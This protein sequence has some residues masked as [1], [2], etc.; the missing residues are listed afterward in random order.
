MSNEEQLQAIAI[1]R[2]LQLELN[3]LATSWDEAILEAAPTLR[4]LNTSRYAA[5]GFL[6]RYDGE[7]ASEVQL[8]EIFD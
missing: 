1:I 8:E 5:S 4:A 6:E 3:K 7:R 2:K